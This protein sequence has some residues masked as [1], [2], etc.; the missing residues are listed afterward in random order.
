MA[1]PASYY[2]PQNLSYFKGK[3]C[4]LLVVPTAMPM[5]HYSKE[6]MMLQFSGIV[7]R[8]DDDGIGLTN[9]T[10]GT[11]SFFFRPHVISIIE[12][13]VLHNK[14]EIDVVK[15]ALA[16]QQEEAKKQATGQ[17]QYIDIKSLQQ[18]VAQA[19]QEAV[20]PVKQEVKQEAAK[21]EAAKLE[22]TKQEAAKLETTKLEAAKLEAAK[23]EAAKLGAEQAEQPEIKR[24]TQTV[25]PVKQE[26][27]QDEAKQEVKH[28]DDKQV[29]HLSKK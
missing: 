14:E 29:W 9:I 22:T 10:S 1:F 16:K 25:I 11:H 12:A 23:L 4:T 7:N 3:I 18:M 13:E 17:P 5:S 6:D 8:A 20:I 26:A 27:K 2:E 24:I 15:K 21:Q 28:D 19:K